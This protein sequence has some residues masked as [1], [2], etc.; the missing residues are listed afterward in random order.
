MWTRTKC[1]LCGEVELDAGRYLVGFEPTT[2]S[3]YYRF[4]CPLCHQDQR[5]GASRQLVRVLVCLGARLVEA[6]DARLVSA[7]EPP[8]GVGY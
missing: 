6:S 5:R 3:T 4:V 1:E 8:V 7:A 2:Q